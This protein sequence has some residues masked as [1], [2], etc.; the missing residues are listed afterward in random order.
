MAS[1]IGRYSRRGMYGGQDLVVSPPRTTTGL[2][3]ETSPL[4]PSSSSSSTTAALARRLASRLKYSPSSFVAAE[5]LATRRLGP[6]LNRSR[7]YCLLI[8]A[9]LPAIRRVRSLAKARLLERDRYGN[10]G[11]VF[12]PSRALAPP[13]KA[14][15]RKRDSARCGRGRHLVRVGRE[16]SSS[17]WKA[18]APSRRTRSA[19][20]G[21]SARR[22]VRTRAR[23]RGLKVDKV[24]DPSGCLQ[25]SPLSPHTPQPWQTVM[26]SVTEFI[27]AWPRSKRR[28]GNPP[29]PPLRQQ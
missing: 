15:L 6:N 21:R 12:M 2:P 18:S 26:F 22:P 4:R 16:G 29:P 1:P 23:P 3:L 24:A 8:R 14:R 5:A 20:V 7:D 9:I 19:A 28:D 25:T 17:S 27:P 10:T 11:M 13:G